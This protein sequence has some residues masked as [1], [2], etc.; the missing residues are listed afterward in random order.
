M[1][2]ISDAVIVGSALS[3]LVEDADSDDAAVESV[4]DL[5]ARLKQATRR[6]ALREER[7]SRRAASRRAARD[8]GR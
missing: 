1:A 8:R 3:K 4:R 6:G 2:A 5:S 7:R